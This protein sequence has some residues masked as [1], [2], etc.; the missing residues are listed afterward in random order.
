MSLT[1]EQRRIIGAMWEKDGCNIDDLVGMLRISESELLTHLQPL[2]E[3]GFC[4]LPNND[5]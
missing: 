1:A 3:A 2:V 4:D 5:R